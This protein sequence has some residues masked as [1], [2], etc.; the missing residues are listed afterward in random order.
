MTARYLYEHLF[1]AHVKFG[2]PTNEFFELVRS[3]SAPGQPL[4]LIPTVRPYDDPG[5]ERFFYR[6]RKIHSTIVHKTHMV[7][8]LDDAQMRRFEELFIEPEWLQ[9]PAPGRLRPEAERQPLRGLR[10]DPAAVA[11]PVPARQR[12]VHHHDLHPRPGLQGADRAQRDQRPVLGHV[13]WTR[14]T[15]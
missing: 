12:P 4:E 2:T 9:P 11:L 6:F 10:A 5:V 14:T 1:L 15:T 7:F 3:K 13:P 8:D